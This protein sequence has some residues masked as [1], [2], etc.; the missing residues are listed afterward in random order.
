MIIESLSH[1]HT[2][3]H[4]HPHP[5]PHTHPPPH[6]HTHCLPLQNY[7]VYISIHNVAEVPPSTGNWWS[8]IFCVLNVIQSWLLCTSGN[9]VDVCI[10][11][12]PE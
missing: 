7:V 9:S 6:P 3:T 12:A 11:R 10:G 4:P 2:H 5:H 1:T 8:K